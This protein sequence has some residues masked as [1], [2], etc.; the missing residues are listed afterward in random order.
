MHWLLR[1]DK[2]CGGEFQCDDSPDRVSRCSF[3]ALSSLE[4]AMSH[5]LQGQS[6]ARALVLR[7]AIDVGVQV[8]LEDIPADEFHA[9][10]VIKA[11]VQKYE[12][13]L[14]Q[15]NAKGEE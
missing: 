12:A 9:L 15:Q 3:C 14:Q 5:T 1:K 8:Q 7:A 11:E 6:I 13:E 10:V 2:L 4:D